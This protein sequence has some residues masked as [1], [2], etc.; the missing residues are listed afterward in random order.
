MLLVL[1]AGENRE[2]FPWAAL[3]RVC[4]WNRLLTFLSSAG[5]CFTNW[6][7]NIRVFYFLFRHV[8]YLIFK[9]VG[10]DAAWL[11]IFFSHIFTTLHSHSLKIASQSL[12]LFDLKKRASQI[13]FCGLIRRSLQKNRQQLNSSELYHFNFQRVGEIYLTS[14]ISI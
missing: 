2:A 4:S 10:F 3:G 1:K 12:I 5:W 11:P 13:I 14:I 9:S 6:W 8:R 7:I